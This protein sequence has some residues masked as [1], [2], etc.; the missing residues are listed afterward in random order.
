MEDILLQVQLI[1]HMEDIMVIITE[2]MVKRIRN[3]RKTRSIRR[4]RRKRDQA[5]LQVVHLAIRCLL[6][7]FSKNLK[8]LYYGRLR[9]I[10]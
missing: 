9:E 3:I 4:I 10:G 7:L 6:D 8:K 1:Q 2:D 5:A